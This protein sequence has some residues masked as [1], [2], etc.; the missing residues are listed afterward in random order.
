MEIDNTA[1]TLSFEDCNVVENSEF[2][3]RSKQMFITSQFVSPSNKCSMRQLFYNQHLVMKWRQLCLCAHERKCLIQHVAS[4]MTNIIQRK[5]TYQQLCKYLRLNSVCQT[6]S[7]TKTAP[8]KWYLI[9]YRPRSLPFQ[10]QAQFNGVRWLRHMKEN[11]GGRWPRFESI[12]HR[13]CFVARWVPNLKSI[14]MFASGWK[15]HTFKLWSSTNSF[16]TTQ[17]SS[18]SC[19]SIAHKKF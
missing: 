17:Q 13:A 3:N 4:Q 19:V 5:H 10:L 11:H 6:R 12:T 9:Q 14:C 18:R 8:L 2:P 16:R 15:I 7:M 1:G